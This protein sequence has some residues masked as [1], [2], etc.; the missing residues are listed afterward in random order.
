MYDCGNVG[1]HNPKHDHVLAIYLR[2]IQPMDT[3]QEAFEWQGQGPGGNVAR[4]GA[5]GYRKRAGDQVTIYRRQYIYTHIYIYNIH[6]WLVAFNVFC[7]LSDI[8][9]HLELSWAWVPCGFS[10]IGWSNVRKN[11][12]IDTQVCTSLI[13]HQ[14]LLHHNSITYIFAHCLLVFDVFGVCSQIL[15]YFKN[16][17]LNWEKMINH[18]A[19]GLGEF[20]IPNSRKNNFKI[21]K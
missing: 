20:P 8:L 15:R 19:Y 6:Y 9:D 10:K 1:R 5:T 18:E 21:R 17:N 11:L 4:N 16:G 13:N 14:S 12:L 3:C 2:S 7:L